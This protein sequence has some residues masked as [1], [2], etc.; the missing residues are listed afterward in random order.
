MATLPVGALRRAWLAIFA[1]AGPAQRPAARTA[2]ATRPMDTLASTEAA[3]R[4]WGRVARPTPTA[5]WAF[6][7][8][9]C[10]VIRPARTVAKPAPPRQA[11]ASPLRRVGRPRSDILSG[12][13]ILWRHGRMRWIGWMPGRELCH[14]VHRV[15]V[16][17]VRRAERR[18]QHLRWGWSLQ[19]AHARAVP[20]WLHVC[21]K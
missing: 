11:R 3:R 5:V 19:H 15:P 1:Q 9:G 12:E 7:R 8:R 10:A 16:L 17:H 14:G 2:P 21:G 20:G 6:A 13:F 18:N 4:T